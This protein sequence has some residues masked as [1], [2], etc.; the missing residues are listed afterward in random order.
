MGR[1]PNSGFGRAI[2]VPHRA[3][4]GQHALGEVGRQRFATAQAL[5]PAQQGAAFAVQEHAPARGCGLHHTDRFAL[6]QIQNRLG[7][8]GH[9]LV[10]QYHR[11]T[12][13]QR[14]VEFQGKD[15][16][17]ERRQRQQ[18]RVSANGQGAGHAMGEAAQCAMTHHHALGL[19]GG[20]GGV[21]HIGQVLAR[22]FDIGV[23][24]AV[25]RIFL[26]VHEQQ[27]LV[28]RQW[29]AFVQVAGSQ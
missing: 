2:Q 24:A 13:R 27:L 6:H 29:Q 23:G 8:Q 5:D 20:T 18:P 17:R 25:A 1:R 3:L 16:E 19:A 28:S 4:L 11:R 22:Q 12:C 14:H 7:V 15:I 9:V 21:D 10:G 26:C